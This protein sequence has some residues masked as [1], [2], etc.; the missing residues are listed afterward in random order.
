MLFDEMTGSRA[1]HDALPIGLAGLADW[2]PENTI[3]CPSSWPVVPV[4]DVERDI[5]SSIEYSR[6]D[7]HERHI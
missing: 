2:D 4:A 7:S 5:R 6:D 3:V 1:A